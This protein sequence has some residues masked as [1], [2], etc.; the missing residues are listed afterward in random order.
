[1]SRFVKKVIVFDGRFCR[2]SILLASPAIHGT[3][4][5]D[6]AVIPVLIGACHIPGFIRQVIVDN[7]CFHMFKSCGNVDFLAWFS[8]RKNP[9]PL[10]MTVSDTAAGPG[11]CK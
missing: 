9:L 11:N 6:T 4:I 8:N 1:M 7:T 2:W 5:P 10:K 3:C